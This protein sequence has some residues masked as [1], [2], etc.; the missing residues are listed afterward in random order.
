MKGGLGLNKNDLKAIKG[1][2]RAKELHTIETENVIDLMD[3]VVMNEHMADP[4]KSTPKARSDLPKNKHHES[5]HD[6]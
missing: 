3:T 4:K 2:K 1:I 6:S 5:I